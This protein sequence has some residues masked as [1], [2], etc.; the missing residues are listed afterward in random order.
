METTHRRTKRRLTSFAA[1]ACCL[2]AA[3]LTDQTAAVQAQFPVPFPGGKSDAKVLSESGPRFPEAYAIGSFSAFVFARGGAPMVVE[4]Q[5]G[6]ENTATIKITV[7]GK[8]DE[9]SFTHRLEPTGN[10]IKLATFLLPEEVF[11]KK[12]VVA[13]LSVQAENRDQKPPEFAFAKLSVQAENRDQKPPNFAL[14]GLCMGEKAC[15]SI[16]L[17]NLSFQPGRVRAAQKEKAAYSFYSRFDF[18][19]VYAEFEHLG[20]TSQGEPANE[21]VNG[22]KIGGVRRGESAGREWDGRDRKGKVSK[23]R[24]QLVVKAWYGDK[25]GGDWTRAWSRQRLVV[26]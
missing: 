26:E 21:S 5:L 7:Q 9:K 12:P 15:G 17:E 25:K 3:H 1:V 22:Q 4:Y 14:Y 6:N 13:K 10:E 2:L 20:Y 8:K 18:D 24:H 19:Q 16:G 11:G 23:G